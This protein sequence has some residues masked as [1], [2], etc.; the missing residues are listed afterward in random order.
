M[1]KSQSSYNELKQ[2]LDHVMEELEREDLDVDKAVEYY[3]KGLELVQAIEKY[4]KS[5]ENKVT[6]LKA[7][8]NTSDK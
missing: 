8:F 1:P 7:K 4:L 3:Q 6:E 2:Q 5:A